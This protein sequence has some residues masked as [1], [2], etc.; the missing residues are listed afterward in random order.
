MDAVTNQTLAQVASLLQ[1]LPPEY[2][3]KATYNQSNSPTTGLT[4]YDLEAEAKVFVPEITPL[5]QMI[6]RVKG[7]GGTAT[8][9]RSVTAINSGGIPMGVAEGERGGQIAITTSDN[10][11]KYVTVGLESNMSWE[12]DLAAMGFDDLRAL[13]VRNLLQ[14]ARI[15]EEQLIVGGNGDVALGTPVLAAVAATTGGAL[16]AATYHVRVVALTLSAYRRASLTVGVPTQHTYSL[17]DGSSQT[18]NGGASQV[19][20]DQTGVVASGSTGSI[21]CTVTAVRGAVAYAWF[22]GAGGGAAGAERIA[23]ITT[24]NKYTFTAVPST[25]T[26]P[27]GFAGVISTDFDTDRSSNSLVFNGLISIVGKSGSGSVFASSD[28][29]VLTADGQGGIT[30]INT[31][32]RAFWDNQKVSPSH[33]FVSAQELINITGKVIAAGG[34]PLFRFQMDGRSGTP[35]MAT[36]TAGAVVGSYLNKTAEGGGR[37]IKVVLHPDVPPGMIVYFSERVS[38]PVPGVINLLQIKARQEWR[39]VEWPLRKRVYEFGVYADEVLQCY[40]PPA[41]GVRCNIK[42]G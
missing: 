39:Q 5:V 6:P 11:S 24:T 8:N 10:S 32:L 19:S 40:F 41:F 38:Y 22:I 17:G 36:V 30:E 18:V 37:L 16:A 4:Y 29:V 28:D 14:S 3:A 13:G 2:L 12:A 23:A 27:S 21:A 7:L 34:T 26:A 42:N 35:D 31:D 15:G 1:S 20:A 9:W 25:I 33:M